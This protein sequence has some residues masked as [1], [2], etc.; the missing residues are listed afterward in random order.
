MVLGHRKPRYLEAGQIFDQNETIQ[1]PV[2]E[3]EL[4]DDQHR[5]VRHILHVALYHPIS[6]SLL[7][8]ATQ[9]IR[10]RC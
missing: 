3:C 4:H 2:R 1:Q 9:S 10:S 8:R 6:L 7:Q 5:L